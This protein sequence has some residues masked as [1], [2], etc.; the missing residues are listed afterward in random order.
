[1]SRAEIVCAPGYALISP[2]LGAV[3]RS[4]IAVS[5]GIVVLSMQRAGSGSS[6]GNHSM[7]SSGFHEKYWVEEQQQ[8]RTTEGAS[9]GMQHSPACE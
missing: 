4:L 9:N 8:S 2:A 1:M 3:C 7:G 6:D 5:I